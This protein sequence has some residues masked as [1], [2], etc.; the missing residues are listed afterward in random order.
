MEKA[1]MTTASRTALL[2]PL[3]ATLQEQI[4]GDVSCEARDLDKH[5][6]D[7]SELRIRPHVVVFP[8]SVRDI[9]H[10]LSFAH[11]HGMPVSVYGQGQ[12]QA[13]GALT[14][15]ISLSLSR[16][17]TAVASLD[18][19]THRI[20]VEAGISIADLRA[21]M[22][23]WGLD[24]PCLTSREE[25]S[26]LGGCVATQT[27]TSKSFA[28]GT[29][30]SW[31]RGLTVV[32]DNGEEHRIEEGI[33]P[34]GRLL[35]LYTHLFPL[36]QH[37][38][39]DIRQFQEKNIPTTGGY[40]IWKQGIGPRQLLDLF[41]GSEGSLGIITSVTMS[42]SPKTTHILPLATY[43]SSSSLQDAV[44][45]YKEHNIDELFLVDKKTLTYKEHDTTLPVYALLEE[46]SDAR[47]MLVGAFHTNNEHIGASARTS[48]AH[49]LASKGYTS[50][51]LDMYEYEMLNHIDTHTQEILLAYGQNYLTPIMTFASCAVP[52]DNLSSYLRA[53]ETYLDTLGVIYL[54]GGY[55]GSGHVSLVLLYDKHTD[56]SF[57]HLTSLTT[58]LHDIVI[59]SHGSIV[60]GD[61]DGITRTP[62][63]SHRFPKQIQDVS[64]QIKHICDPSSV[65]GNTKKNYTSL[66]Q[67]HRFLR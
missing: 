39:K 23:T 15:G 46:E 21:R 26:T 17:M 19:T 51:L 48:C 18:V 38:T 11:E 25:T 5:S 29:C 20:T 40:A 24:I 52:H 60:Y 41:I 65:F 47:Y 64:H 43:V 56:T 63:M 9:K 14:E 27:V 2:P 67:Q 34:S 3:F 36:L 35:E 4:L 42:C 31:V 28:H 10:V 57:E 33:T 37:H 53:I 50:V 62:L 49:T 6:T 32:L 12:G 30:G 54:C 44:A 59:E 58:K 45:C 1:S 66:S 61:G 8:Q 13:A 22:H 16:Y 7:M 55:V